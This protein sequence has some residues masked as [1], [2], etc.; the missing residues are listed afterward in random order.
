MDA[1]VWSKLQCSTTV[2]R[3]PDIER[4]IGLPAREMGGWDG[5]E[6]TLYTRVVE[7]GRGEYILH[8]APRLYVSLKRGRVDED[9]DYSMYESLMHLGEKGKQTTPRAQSTAPLSYTLS[10]KAPTP[11][12]KQS[13]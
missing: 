13:Q 9:A 1:L 2:P 7:R 8:R 10:S 12:D 5:M 11:R 3:A 4:C 6:C